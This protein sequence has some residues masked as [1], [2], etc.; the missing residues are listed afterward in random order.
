MS[1]ADVIIDISHERVDRPFTYRIPEGLVPRISVGCAVFVPFGQGNTLRKAY[2]IGLH[3]E[4]Q[5]SAGRIKEISGIAEGD[6]PAEAVLLRLAAWMKHTYGSTMIAALKTV[7][8][9]SKKIRSRT[10]PSLEEGEDRQT[11]F[12]EEPVRLTLSSEQRQ[13]VEGILADYDAGIRKT[14]LLCGITGS[15]K[16]EVYIRLIQEMV[17]RGKQAI[18][19]IPEIALSWQTLSRF[20]RHF[21]NRVSVMHSML[22]RG[23][24]FDH[25]ELAR[26]GK[27]DVI[28]GPRSALFT[29][30]SN[31]GLII[32]DEEHEGSYK[33]ETMPKYHAR[34]TAEQLAKLVP[35]G[36]S[37]LLGSA[38]PSMEA[39]YRAHHGEYG[40]YRLTRRLTG[41]QLPS[42]EI[43]DLREELRMGNRTP[44]SDTLQRHLRDRLSKKEQAMLFINRRGMAGFVSCR[45]CGRVF[46]CPHCDVSLSAHSG[47]RLLCHYC[48]YEE[49]KPQVCPDCGS[50]YVSGFR[51][52]TEAI[53]LQVKRMLPEA[54]VLRM[55]AD[56]TRTKGSY[57]R[58]LA[59][60][61]EGE[62]DILIGT[63]MIVK[64]HDFP[65]VTLVG[66]LAADL[67][68]NTGDYRASERTWQLIV[69]A[70][71][72]AGR[73]ESPGHVV[74]QTYQ[75]EHY[76]VRLAASQQIDAFYEEEMRY[77]RMMHYP[78]AAHL[79]AV[80]IYATKEQEGADY[81]RALRAM[82]DR[83]LSVNPN[84]TVTVVGPAPAAI[85]R[86]A[87]VFRFG[88]Y[89][90]ST[91]RD[92]LS[93]LKD[94]AEEEMAENHAAGKYAGVSLQ[95]DL[96]PLRGF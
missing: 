82:F 1:Y 10:R 31:P 66:I 11:G 61:S 67:S 47:G 3:Q 96:D 53:E 88:L 32:I 35:G 48:G 6:L 62:A 56:T 42:V 39:L 26:Q 85:G 52:G 73:G 72:R 65:G 69:Q 8:P 92:R 80:Q 25:F 4:S 13:T 87:D 36:A 51:A 55:D 81:A 37:V 78:P 84:Q 16:T 28:I 34:E 41:G 12:R 19:L 60:F 27:I 64:G 15:G 2:V 43:V 93:A 40:L 22:S 49:S 23:E 29:P 50:R 58:I 68:L 63:Q 14:Y 75:P 74:I 71:G 9:A 20:V 57:D 45:S 54:H 76:A 86:I 95:F 33:S 90:K 5:L 77:R 91:D 18:V 24:R 79:M 94:L 17:A 83:V 7:L 21:G 59:A 70:A 30:F 46:R 38:T 44:F 89:L